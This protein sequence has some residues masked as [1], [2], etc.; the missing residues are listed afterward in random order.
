MEGVVHVDWSQPDDCE[1]E[2]CISA[3]VHD[4]KKAYAGNENHKGKL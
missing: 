3:A 1:E 2:R 4:E